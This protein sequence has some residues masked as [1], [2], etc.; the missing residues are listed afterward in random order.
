MKYL[1]LLASLGL[2]ACASNIPGY[3]G[4]KALDRPAV[5]QGARDCINARMK[6]TVE[7]LSQKTQYGVTMVPVN[8][9]CDPY[10]HFNQRGE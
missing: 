3:E 9:H 1:A 4:P 5:I 8:V 10:R 2:T 7:Y 6:P